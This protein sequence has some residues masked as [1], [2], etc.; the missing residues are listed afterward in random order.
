MRFNTRICCSCLMAFTIGSM[1]SI[2]LAGLADIES[3]RARFSESNPTTNMLK[4]AQGQIRRIYGTAF[5]HGETPLDAVTSFKDLWSGIYGVPAAQLNPAPLEEGRSHLQPIVYRPGTGNYQFTGAYFSQQIDGVPVFGTRLCV[6][7]RNEPGYPVVLASSELKHIGDWAPDGNGPAPDRAGAQA[8]AERFFG[9]PARLVSEPTWMIFAGGEGELLDPRLSMRVEATTGRKSDGTYRRWLLL[10]DQRTNEILYEENRVLNCQPQGLG[11]AF[12][13]LASAD[14]TGTVSG[15]ATEWSG[16]DECEP[17]V[18]TVLPYAQVTASNGQ[19]AYADSNGDYV[20]ATAEGETVNITSGLIG[21]WFTVNNQIGEDETIT[22]EASDGGTG[23]FLHN[24]NN[25]DEHVRAQVNAYLEANIVRDFTLQFNPE[26]P[27][28]ATQ[29]QFPT[30]VNLNDSC[31]AYY[32]YSSTNYYIAAGGCNN[33]AFSV[34][35][36]HEY[37]HHLVSCAGSGQGAYG[38]GMGDVMGVLITGDA[39][40]ARGFFQG[41]CSTGIRNADNNC[42]FLASGCSSCGSEIHACGQLISGCVWDVRENLMA[43]YPNGNDIVSNLAVNAMLLHNGSAIDEAIVI[44]YLTLDDD[45]ADIGNGTPHYQEISLGFWAHG[46]DAPQLDFL[47]FSFPDGQPDKVDPDGGTTMAVRI[48]ANLSEV[49][50]GSEQVWIDS[51]SG[52][53]VLDLPS[54]GEGSY[55]VVFPPAACG[56]SVGYVFRAQTTDGSLVFNPPDWPDSYYSAY[57]AEDVLVAIDDNFETDQGWQVTGTS[58]TPWVRVVPPA[59]GPAWKPQSDFDGSGMC[60]LTHVQAELDGTTILTSPPIDAGDGG[61]LTFAF[62]LAQRQSNPA[63]PED[64]MQLFV[65]TDGDGADWTLVRDWH[66]YA[67]EWRT[68]SLTIGPDGEV[69]ASSNLFLRFVAIDEDVDNRVKAGI[70]AV[71]MISVDCESAPCP[72]DLSGDGMV[73]VEDLLAVIAGWG[74]PDGDAT[75]D[76]MTNVDDLLQVI[77]DWG[78]TCD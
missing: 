35:V 14:V 67:N 40:L 32:D 9:A 42:Q 44:D 43:Q 62:W 23:D 61:T 58:T 27:V 29:V 18:E 1:S 73:N 19:T 24:W 65:S 33:T 2:S 4:S 55:E 52:Y 6:L 60:Y 36:H 77:G 75:G 7:V 22:Q 39:Q 71:Q 53:Q 72:S 5:G 54:T 57:A 11:T 47:S 37:G 3:A 17:E 59:D 41:Q 13:A 30:N 16:A 25:A 45:D 34:I 63:Q 21:Q 74:G 8:A 69:P 31:N 66:T 64:G 38:E 28:I 78:S 48:D 56:T 26:Y 20:L 68:D 49:L 70:D 10:V 51:G 46:L 50:E 15:M 12:T 76:G